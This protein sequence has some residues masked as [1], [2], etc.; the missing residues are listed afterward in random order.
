[1]ADMQG[2]MTATE[3][4]ELWF[5]LATKTEEERK[6]IPFALFVSSKGMLNG[7]EAYLYLKEKRCK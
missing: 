1:M 6:A 3:E 4:I 5:E 2:R 7:Q